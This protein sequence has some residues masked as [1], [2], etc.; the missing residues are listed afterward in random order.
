M[1]AWIPIH[2]SFHYSVP[3]WIHGPWML[4]LHVS[5]RVLISF[6]MYQFP[7]HP[8]THIYN[9]LCLGPSWGSSR[10]WGLQ[11]LNFHKSLRGGSAPL[12]TQDSHFSTAI[13][14][15]LT[16]TSATVS[17]RPKSVGDVCMKECE[18]GISE[19]RIKQKLHEELHWSAKRSWDLW[20]LG[21]NGLWVAP[22]TSLNI[23][24]KCKQIHF[25]ITVIQVTH[26]IVVLLFIL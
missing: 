9:Q 3:L 12:S 26:F 7:S 18:T 19:K 22:E 23:L 16:Q 14:R 11:K 17:R 8:P 1:W 2:S 20:E 4:L 24:K 13:P 15:V 6:K 25:C 21:L 10:L 5:E